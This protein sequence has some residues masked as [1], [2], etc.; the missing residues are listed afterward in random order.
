MGWTVTGLGLCSG[1]TQWVAQRPGCWGSPTS[2]C[3]FTSCSLLPRSPA[4]VTSR[5]KTQ[6]VPRETVS[7]ETHRPLDRATVLGQPW[8]LHMARAASTT[9]IRTWQL[10]S[11]AF[12]FNVTTQPVLQSGITVRSNTATRV[13]TACPQEPAYH[14][15]SVAERN[16][17]RSSRS[18][19]FGLPLDDGNRPSESGVGGCVNPHAVSRVSPL[20][21]RGEASLRFSILRR[22][23]AKC[24]MNMPVC[25][26][27]GCVMSQRGAQAPR[28]RMTSQEGRENL[29][30]N[31][32]Y[33]KEI[34]LNK[35]LRSQFS[36]DYGLHKQKEV[37][38]NSTALYKFTSK[39]YLQ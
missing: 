13:A 28:D 4:H 17:W 34:L 36:D 12:I 20:T 23:L 31:Y 2:S 24:P 19:S 14:L 35:V 29:W 25:D 18:I 39:L 9:Q 5:N 15:C 3:P 7:G 21:R 26:L 11:A 16:V 1:H 8:C 33:S 22:P 37:L 6:L 38:Q 27:P 30:F 10:C 32:T